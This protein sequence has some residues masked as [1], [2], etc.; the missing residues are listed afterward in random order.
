MMWLGDNPARL[1]GAV[2]VARHE[3]IDVPL[4]HFARQLLCLLYA[5]RVQLALRLSLHYLVLVVVCLAV[6]HQQKCRH[7]ALFYCF[8]CKITKNRLHFIPDADVFS[9]NNPAS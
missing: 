5:A 3:G 7:C 4:R 2:Q 9:C 6:S 1:N 8:A